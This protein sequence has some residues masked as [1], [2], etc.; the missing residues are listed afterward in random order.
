MLFL[1]MRYYYTYK[2]TCTEGSL[3]DYFYLGKHIT[4]NLDD[5]YKGSGKII[6]DYY[7]KYPNGYNIE[8][9][10]FYNNKDEL[11]T[12]ERALIE[13][14]IGGKYCLNLT[15]GGAG[16]GAF[17]RK[18]SEETKRKRNASLKGKRKGCEP[19]NKGKKMTTEFSKKVSEGKTGKPLSDEHKQKISQSSKLHP[20]R[21][22]T[23]GMKGKTHSEETKLKISQSNKGKSSWQKG[24]PSAIKGRHRV[25]REDGTYYMSK[26]E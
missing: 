26:G 17:G 21:H 23:F 18:D 7:K 5:G 4:S 1:T 8:I 11:A 19:W 12:A 14:Y 24:K 10:N 25:Y 9:L 15:R 20:D 13:Q 2:I 16:G 22:A 6:N 3:K